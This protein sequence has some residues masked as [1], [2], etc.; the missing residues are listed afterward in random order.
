MA[1]GLRCGCSRTNCVS[2]CSGG[3]LQASWR[4]VRLVAK[5]RQASYEALAAKPNDYRGKGVSFAT[6][7]IAHP[8]NSLGVVR[9]KPICDGRPRALGARAQ[10]CVLRLRRLGPGKDGP[11][12]GIARELFFGRGG[13]LTRHLTR[14]APGMPK[15]ARRWRFF[16]CEG[17]IRCGRSVLKAVWGC[18]HGSDDAACRPSIY[19]A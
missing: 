8:T 7:R 13:G 5:T 12:V 1:S 19:Y 17:T 11:L 16:Q 10:Y 4:H 6:N 9:R 2:A 18:Q 15:N 3:T 14:G